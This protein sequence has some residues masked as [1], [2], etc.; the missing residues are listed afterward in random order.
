MKSP[1]FPL[2][3]PTLPRRKRTK[4]RSGKMC[5]GKEGAEGSRAEAPCRHR[6]FF[7]DSGPQRFLLESGGRGEGEERRILKKN[8]CGR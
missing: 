1:P 5:E 3:L 2:P 4:K 8:G 6:K 7:I